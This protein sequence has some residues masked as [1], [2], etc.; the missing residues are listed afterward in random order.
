MRK[1]INNVFR[2][3]M[4]LPTSGSL[5]TVKIVVKNENHE[6]VIRAKDFATKKVITQRIAGSKKLTHIL[7]NVAETLLGK[8]PEEMSY[9]LTVCVD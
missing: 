3:D 4:P 5:A 1:S 8:H 2:S 7:N 6:M 9:N